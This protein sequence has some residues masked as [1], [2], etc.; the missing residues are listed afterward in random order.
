MI[1]VTLV[2]LG[3]AGYGFVSMLGYQRLAYSG[4]AM[5]STFTKTSMLL[6]KDTTEYRRGDIVIV[7]L[8]ALT[9]QPTTPQGMGVTRIIGV[10]G[11][12]IACCAEKGHIRVNGKE[13][14]EPYATIPDLGQMEFETTVAPDSVFL[15]GDDRGAAADSRLSAN[16]SGGGSVKL[17][18]LRG[19]VVATGNV[20][21]PT[22]LEPTPVFADA[23]LGAK[24]DVDTEL[25]GLRTL[26]ML[27]GI[28][29]GVGVIGVL[30]FAVRAAGRRRKAAAG[31]PGR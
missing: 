2:G 31:P 8:G 22:M 28:V 26:V 30:V 11:D 17:S 24:S 27:G 18:D 1:V 25:A 20:M 12:K 3:L 16:E 4:G 5:G 15:A 13:I 19:R 10:A 14:V 9:G 21:T 23:G 7:D 29:A 6:A